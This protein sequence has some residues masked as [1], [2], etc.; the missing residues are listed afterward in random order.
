M[1]IINVT[2]KTFSKAISENID[3]LGGMGFMVAALM[4]GKDNMKEAIADVPDEQLLWV[5]TDHVAAVSGPTKISETGDVVF[6]IYFRFPADKENAI[7]I[8]IDDYK[9]FILAWA[10]EVQPLNEGEYTLPAGYKITTGEDG[11]T[12]NVEKKED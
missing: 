7:W 3:D 8:K 10:G 11:A 12:V 2:Q 9:R 4:G 1:A 6:R 5:N